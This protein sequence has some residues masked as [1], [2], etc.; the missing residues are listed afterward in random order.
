MRKKRYWKTQ[1]NTKR[2]TLQ[3]FHLLKAAA[4]II[5]VC[6]SGLL[7]KQRERQTD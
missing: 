3:L 1:K 5:Y 7:S 2:K 4:T 6:P